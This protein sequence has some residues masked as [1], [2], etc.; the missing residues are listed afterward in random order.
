LKQHI[1][2]SFQV[3]VAFWVAPPIISEHILQ[4]NNKKNNLI[5][6]TEEK[7][8]LVRYNA[9][10]NMRKTSFRSSSW[11]TIMIQQILMH[12]NARNLATADQQT[13]YVLM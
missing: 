6:H 1:P 13:L 3:E 2:R 9:H 12:W 5:Y 11:I 4:P 8:E 10:K 7:I